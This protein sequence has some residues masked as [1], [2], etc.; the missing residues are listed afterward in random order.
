MGRVNH[1]YIRRCLQGRGD[2]MTDRQFFTQRIFAGHLEDIAAAQTRRYQYNRRIRVKLIWDS[3]D[4]F[5][6]STNNLLIIINA[7]C[8]LV[9]KAKG[10]LA[11]YWVIVGLFAH[12]LGHV[13]YTDFLLSQ[14][15]MNRF[16]ALKWYPNKPKLTSKKAIF[17]EKDM[18]DYAQSAPENME[19]LVAISQQLA[20]IIE[21]G[22]IENR[23]LQNF[24]GTIGI[25]L[26]E[27]REGFK[28]ML[29]T[30]TELIDKEDEGKMHIFQSIM[31]VILSYALYG[32]IKYGSESLSNVRIQ[33]VFE[34]LTTI[35]SAL[36][37]PSFKER[38][39]VVNE[40]MV[41][42]W[43]YLKD[44]CEKCKAQFIKQSQNGGTQT[45][46]QVVSLNLQSLV[47]TSS[48]GEGNSKPVSN[49]RGITIKSVTASQRAAIKATAGENKE[50]K[51][52]SV[53]DSN[54]N[55]A[56]Q[57]NGPKSENESQSEKIENQ[58]GEPKGEGDSNETLIAP[59]TMGE[60]GAK[61][62]ITSSETQRIKSY[63]TDMVSEPVGGTVERDNEY[64]NQVYDR[65]ASDIA[66]LLE[67]MREKQV[68]EELESKRLRELNDTAKNISYGDI[69]KGV[70]VRVHRITDVD[71][72]L[73]D[74]YNE[75]APSLIDIAKQLGR[76]LVRRLHESEKGGKQTS[77]LMGRRLDSHALHR[78]DGKIFYKNNLPNRPPSLAVA[79]LLDES[80]SMRGANRSTYARATG[81]ILYNFCDS[82]D[83]PIMIYGHS[84]GRCSSRETVDLH[85][86]SEFE[87]F[88][89]D[90]KY[91][92]M[93]IGARG[94][95]R[96]GAAIRFVAEQLSKR[97]EE[98]KLLILVSDGQPNGDGYGGT[99]AEEDLRGIKQEY[100]RKGVIFVAAAI[101]DDKANI[102]RIYGDSF[103]DITDLTQLPI[104]LTNVVKRH[105]K[106]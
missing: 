7:G 1:K 87:S 3:N 86:Y 30:V 21:D 89:Y 88:D 94:C 77:L 93:D 32:E 63:H 23:I 76:N 74:Q 39:S 22:H 57:E 69:H 42:C 43:E 78:T 91:R 51:D 50:Q 59:P 31:Q 101:G 60:A 71:Q 26:E 58:N 56:G 72:R 95:N 106:I 53:S 102:E 65:A 34:L 99:A 17:N 96:D 44:F 64:V 81:I 70:N 98:I 80:G 12:E 92:L 9:T 66:E 82:L 75:I 36:L 84:T 103:L 29:P 48:I 11:R 37:N 27:M 79:Y 20:N 90:D 47:G 5:I 40:I 45:I 38:I 10:R 15:H 104:K 97:P 2:T 33:T 83:I 19:A 24:K 68:M 28:K 13:L 49:E 41:H 35:D 105:I 8:A 100:Q 4:E 55:G 73:I 54:E 25:G 16:R 46:S 85:S 62:P 6:A 67:Q 14:T 18:W 52:A 61:Q